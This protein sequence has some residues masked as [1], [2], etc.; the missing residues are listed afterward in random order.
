MNFIIHTQYYPPETG[1]P[2]GRLSELA[3]IMTRCGHNVTVLTAMPNYP[4][5]QLY[6]GYRGLFHREERN[7]VPVIRTWIYPSKSVRMLPRLTNYFSFVFSSFLQGTAFLP[8]ADYILTE[9]PPLFLGISGYALSR[10]KRARWIF[11]VS[12]LWP[13]S[14][15][16]LGVVGKGLPLTI[17]E[18]LEAFCYRKSWLVTGQSREILTGVKQCVPETQT[19]HLSNGADTS[20]FSPALRSPELHR[21][22]GDGAPCVAVYAGLHG[23]A[24]GLDQVLEAANRLRDLEGVLKIVFIGDG[25]EKEALRQKAAGLKMIKFLPPRP[26]EEIPGILASSDFALVPLTTDIPGA[27]PS[28]IYEAMASCLPV[29][30]IASG[31]A[32]RIL[33]DAGA[34]IVVRPGE[35]GDIAESIR[36]LALNSTARKELGANGRRAALSHYDRSSIANNFLSFLKEASHE[37][38]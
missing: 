24:Q 7:G 30:L 28:K 18:Q 33:N 31:E 23:I 5:G 6:P 11:N 3:E 19:Y 12:D 4:I 16:R 13:E 38:L 2:Q 17:S 25:P 14:A 21:E 29:L 10:I 36:Y 26:K 35:T 37:N 15:V 22:L 32:T 20:R 8:K 27:V 9:S 1:A 34:G